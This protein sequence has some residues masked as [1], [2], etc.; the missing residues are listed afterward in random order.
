MYHVHQVEHQYANGMT[1]V[2][3]DHRQAAE[4]YKPLTSRALMYTGCGI[5]FM[6]NKGWVV[7]SRAGIDASPKSLLKT[8]FRQT[9][10]R[11]PVSRDHRK[12]FLDCIRSGA[13]TVCP[14]DVAVRTDTVCHLD[15]IAIRLGR[16][17]TWDPDRECFVG[18]DSANRLLKRPLRSPWHLG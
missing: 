18:D 1:M 14:I 13:Q 7:V 17:L 9:D 6:G 16:K 3:T 5:L 15:D 11:L 2:H 4:I 10:T 12:N 8:V